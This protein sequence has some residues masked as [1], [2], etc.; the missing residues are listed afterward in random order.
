[1]DVNLNPI[2]DNYSLSDYQLVGNGD[3]QDQAYTV[4]S[5]GTVTLNVVDSKNAANKKTIQITGLAS[6]SGVTAGRTTVQ[7]SDNSVKVTDSTAN[8]DTHTYDIQV[9][10][11]KIPA[12]LKVQYSGD[13]GTTGSNTM[14][15]ATAFN[16]TAG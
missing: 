11:A 8:G 10:Y 9:D 3:T 2:L 15:T 14:D 6:Q 16:G 12:N 4:G 5:D 1:M 7:S 13:N